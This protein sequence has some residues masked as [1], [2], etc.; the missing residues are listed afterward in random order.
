ML[1]VFVN[2]RSVII[3]QFAVRYE[4][5]PFFCFRCG[6]MG[7]YENLC[8]EDEAMKVEGQYGEWWCRSPRKIVE[9]K[10]GYVSAS[11]A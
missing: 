1:T 10:R 8:T 11:P 9:E 7:H 3:M 4:S 6:R 5:M 2:T